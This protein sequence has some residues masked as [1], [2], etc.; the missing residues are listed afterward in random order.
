MNDDENI[1]I[2]STNSD[3]KDKVRTNVHKGSDTVY[4]YIRFNNLLDKDSI[5]KE[6]MDVTD[7]YGYIMKTYI[8]YDE[9]RNFIIISPIDTYHEN[10]YYILNLKEG[11]KSEKG[12]QLKNKINVLF[13]LLGNELSEF[14]ILKSTVKVPEPIERPP[15]YDEL[16]TTNALEAYVRKLERLKKD[17]KTAKNTKEIPEFTS[18][19]MKLNVVALVIGIVLTIASIPIK[20]LPISIIALAIAVLGFIHT[21]YQISKKEFRAIL[22]YNFGVYNFKKEKYDKAYLQFKKAHSLYELNETIEFAAKKSKFYI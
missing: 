14:E 4:W 6:S 7:K 15:N 1:K 10:V 20:N 17:K 12:N 5:T 16:V 2:L 8:T 13:K 3:V 22:M 21:V 19:K 11:I 18:H 9:V